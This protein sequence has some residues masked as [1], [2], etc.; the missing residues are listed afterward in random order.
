[1]E[2]FE[3]VVPK[4]NLVIQEY[5]LTAHNKSIFVSFIKNNEDFL[6]DLL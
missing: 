4:E 5:L 3:E 2:V 6:D 1:M